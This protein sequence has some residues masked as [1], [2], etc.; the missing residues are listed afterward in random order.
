MTKARTG[1]PFEHAKKPLLDIRA[2][3]RR[4]IRFF[5]YAF[6]LILIS[7]VIGMI[8]YKYFTGMP[9]VSS[10]YNASMILTGMGPADEMKTPGAQLFA[11]LYALFSGVVFLS[12][13]AVM[14]SPLIHRFLHRMHMEE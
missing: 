5:L 7:L 10:F 13:V 11:G 3:R 14:F 1:Y 12:T 6:V 9:W 2:F 8:G 4:Q